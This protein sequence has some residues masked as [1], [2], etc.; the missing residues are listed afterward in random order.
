MNLKET[1]GEGV[2]SV[3]LD[4]NGGQYRS[5]M[6]MV[7]NLR[8]LW[9]MGI[10]SLANVSLTG[11]VVSMESCETDGE[12]IMRVLLWSVAAHSLQPLLYDKNQI[13]LEQI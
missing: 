1:E 12:V 2:A 5:V 9:K 7:M 8:A 10:I 6:N 11:R 3:H 4:E 13:R